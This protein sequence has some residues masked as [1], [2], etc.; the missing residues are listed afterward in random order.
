M[1]LNFISY[2]NQSENIFRSLRY[3]FAGNTEIKPVKIPNLGT[4]FSVH[5]AGLFL[6]PPYNEDEDFPGS[7]IF[8]T[9]GLRY[10]TSHTRKKTSE[11]YHI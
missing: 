3:G 7:S 10:N 4:Y 1:G 11:R 5:G 6:V 9:N 8:Y 2:Q